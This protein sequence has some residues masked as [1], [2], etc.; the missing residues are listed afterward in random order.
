M[1]ITFARPIKANGLI[2]LRKR[3]WNILRKLLP[4]SEVYGKVYY[5]I[6]ENGQ[7]SRFESDGIILY[8]KNLFILE[9]KAGALSTSARRGS[10][11]RMKKDVSALI[12]SAYS[13]ALR[14]KKYIEMTEKPRFEYEDG[15]EALTI[16][17]KN[18]VENIFLV[19]VT[20][21]SLGDLAIR[22][23]SLKH[24]KLIQGKGWPWSVFINDLRV[25]AEILESPSQFLT[26]LKRRIQA[27]DFPQFDL[28]DE[29]D[30][31]MFY[32]REGLYLDKINKKEDGKFTLHGYTE[33]L[34]RYYDFLAGRVSSGE[35]P[36]LRTSAEYK[37]I[38]RN[39]EALGKPGFTSVTTTLLDFSGEAHKDILNALNKI[40][41]LS[42]GDGKTHDATFLFQG[43]QVGCDLSCRS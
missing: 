15:S 7:R 27:N 24:L 11:E 32:L 37:A 39:I 43:K 29:L 21:E 8:D 2:F 10:L 35:K 3:P 26:F 12:D 28:A 19:N 13:Q 14:T 20:L 31:L 42:L 17:D 5:E 22:L 34:D 41:E 9:A 36:T 6:E 25:I 30:F 18:N 33:E 1:V 40:K 23:N 38:I 16:L 4:G